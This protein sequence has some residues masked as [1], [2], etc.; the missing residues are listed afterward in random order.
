[1]KKKILSFIL[2]IL[3]IF[4][5][6]GVSSPVL[7]E[8]KQTDLYFFN[9]NGC[10]HC[11]KEKIF[12]DSLKDKYPGLLIHEYKVTGSRENVE[13]LQMIGKKLG[14]DVSGVP[15]TVI[16]EHY[17]TGYLNDETTGKE[18]EEAVRCAVETGCSD[19]VKDLIKPATAEG[20]RSIPEKIKI[21]VLGEIE[22]KNLSL[23]ALTFVIALVDGFNPCAMWVLLFLISLLLG[24]KDRKKMWILG[25]AFIISSAFM[26]FLF[27]SAWLNLFLFLGFVVWVRILIGSVSLAVGGYQVRDFFVNKYGGC[28]V[29]GGEKRKRIFE[30]LRE[31]TQKK[32][33]LIALAGIILLAFAV[34]LVELVCSAGLPAIFTQILALNNLPAWQYYLYLVLYILVFMLDDLFVFFV[35]MT[36]LKAVGV[37]SKYA[38]YSHLIG[39]AI[40]FLIG[41]FMLFKPEVLMFG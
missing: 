21:P 6:F 2:G 25:T 36:T 33:F 34:N 30:W 17:F 1:M 9:A 38:R 11:K 8:E 10:P 23:P 40:V 7:A 28:K 22:T 24:M 12:L 39:G 13:L 31:I 35:A 32:D 19:V 37:E 14:V 27:L 3:S 16:G 5:V 41:I 29:T 4:F 18:I 26:Y 15:F 20:K